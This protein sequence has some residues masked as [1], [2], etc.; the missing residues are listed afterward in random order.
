MEPFLIMMETYTVS[1]HSCLVQN[2]RK[3]IFFFILWLFALKLHWKSFAS[4]FIYSQ[5]TCNEGCCY[6]KC[7]SAL[8][9]SNCPIVYCRCLLV[10]CFF[11]AQ[12]L[13][14]CEAWYTNRLSYPKQPITVWRQRP[15][16]SRQSFLPWYELMINWPFG[17]AF[18]FTWDRIT[19]A[20][21]QVQ[22]RTLTHSQA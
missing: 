2:K 17:P 4:L 7:F 10:F 5:G 18:I 12:Y 6:F 9:K 19:R 3:V 1:I 14:Q 13:L 20:T 15:A 8:E 21:G 22:T 11:F 16:V